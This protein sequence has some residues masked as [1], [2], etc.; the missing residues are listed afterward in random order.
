MVEPQSKYYNIIKNNYK[1]NNYELLEIGLD[2]KEGVMYL[3]E[4]KIFN[5]DLPTHNH[6]TNKKTNTQVKV[7]TLDKISKD[8]NKWMIVKIDVDG[9][10]VDI[11]KGGLECLKK[12]A[13]LIIEAHYERFTS[14][15]DIMTKNNFT[16]NGIVDLCYIKNSFW[17]CDL[18]FINNEFSKK[19]KQFFPDFNP[20]DFIVYNP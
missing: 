9:K 4:S 11:L 17:Q 2:E 7:S 6:L 19:H 18:I 5:S 16:L 15:T 1:N 20:K 3:E 8:Y 10:D 14:I 12:T 13:F